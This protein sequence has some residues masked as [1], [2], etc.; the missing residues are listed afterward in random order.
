MFSIDRV[1]LAFMA[2]IF[3]ILIIVIPEIIGYLIGG[4]L[5]LFGIITLIGEQ[6]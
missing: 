4:Y 3:G 2:I 5:I 1:L 6:S